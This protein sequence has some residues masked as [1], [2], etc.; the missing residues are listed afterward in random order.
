MVHLN[1]EAEDC[2]FNITQKAKG[3][4]LVVL[5]NGKKENR[6]KVVFK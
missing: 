5:S 4:Y 6:G 2:S 1:N 3:V